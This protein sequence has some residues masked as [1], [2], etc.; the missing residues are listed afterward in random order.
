MFNLKFEIGTDIEY[1]FCAPDGLFFASA[2][3]CQFN[4]GNLF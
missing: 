2:L 4:M 1:Y 3:F